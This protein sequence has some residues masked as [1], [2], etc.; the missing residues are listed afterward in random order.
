MSKIVNFYIDD[1][2]TRHPTNDRGTTPEHGYDWFAFGGVLIDEEDEIKAR[3]LHA[4]FCKN[5]D[6]TQP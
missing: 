3:E 2:G 6:I 4:N 1:S 5:W